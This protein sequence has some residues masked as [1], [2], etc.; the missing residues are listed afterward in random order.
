MSRVAYIASKA[1]VNAGLFF[2]LVSRETEI[3]ATYPQRTDE[4]IRGS[5]Y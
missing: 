2:G 5:K 3:D 1:R 4:V